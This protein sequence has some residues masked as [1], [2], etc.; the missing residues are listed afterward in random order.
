MTKLEKWLPNQ[1]PAQCPQL[2]FADTPQSWWLMGLAG[3]PVTPHGQVIKLSDALSISV[4]VVT[5][6]HG[7][8]SIATDIG[9]P[10]DHPVWFLFSV[11]IGRYR[12]PG[13]IPKK[14][15]DG[16]T[17]GEAPRQRQTWIATDG[18]MWLRVGNPAVTKSR[19]G[20]RFAPPDLKLTLQSKEQLI[21]ALR[22][23]AGL[24]EKP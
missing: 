24:V 8:I 21:E 10:S 7:Y 12:I 14:S 6:W 5:A 17:L 20:R 3:H 2:E 1:A 9:R 16:K 15:K 19:C 4:D 22:L 11:R 13:H 23:H 18:E